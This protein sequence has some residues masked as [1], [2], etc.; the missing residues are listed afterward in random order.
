MHRAR[1][2][3]RRVLA[4]AFYYSGALWLYAAFRLR[5]RAVALMYHRVLPQGADSFSTDAI[6]V[7]P[8]TFARQVAF[9]K[10]HFNLLDVDTLRRCLEQGTFPDRGCVITFDDGWYDN[11]RHALPILQEHRAPAL[12]FVATGYVG[13]NSTF[14]QEQVTRLLFRALRS[15]TCPAELL[16]PLGLESARGATDYEARRRVRDAVTRLKAA[17]LDEIER[18]RDRLLQLRH[19]VRSDMATIGSWTGTPCAVWLPHPAHM[20]DRTRTATSH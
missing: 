9:L 16:Q 20:S 8:A 6:V 7:S 2:W 15:P 11:E 19:L 12:F 3:L 14:W 10:R 17:P 1:A 13:T 5:G 18:L 4:F